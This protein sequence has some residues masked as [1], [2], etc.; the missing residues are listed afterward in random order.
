MRGYS[1]VFPSSSPSASRPRLVAPPAVRAPSRRGD[2]AFDGNTDAGHHAVPSDAF[3]S[4]ANV[5][6]DEFHCA[7]TRAGPEASGRPRGEPL[8]ARRRPRC[9]RSV[10]PT[11]TLALPQGPVA[12]RALYVDL[13]QPDARPRESTPSSAPR[14]R[15]SSRSR[16]RAASFSAGHRH[17]CVVSPVVRPSTS[18]LDAIRGTGPQA[19]IFRG[20]AER[21]ATGCRRSTRVSATTVFTVGQPIAMTEKMRDVAAT[22]PPPRGS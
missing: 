10:F 1:I 16:R 14:R 21:L 8:R 5:P 12:G 11:S 20:L 9:T 19:A 2:G 4:T 6:A 15:S 18:M 17:A 3:P 13:D 22:L 7:E